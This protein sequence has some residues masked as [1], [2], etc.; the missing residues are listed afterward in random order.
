M[1]GEQ[2][3]IGADRSTYGFELS[4]N[5]ARGAR[6]VFVEESPLERTAKERLEPLSV[7]VLP[8]A[9]RNALP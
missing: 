2:D 6:I 3:I 5:S 8:L 4:A 1:A 7:T 9:L